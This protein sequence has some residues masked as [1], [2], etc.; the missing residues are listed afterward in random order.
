MHYPADPETGRTSWSNQNLLFGEK[1]VNSFLMRCEFHD[2]W[3]HTFHKR[4]ALT[5]FR[6][7]TSCE[8]E[9]EDEN[10]LRLFGKK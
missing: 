9:V 1:L 2:S 7:P 3:I 4:K 6:S 8:G 10:I 5:M